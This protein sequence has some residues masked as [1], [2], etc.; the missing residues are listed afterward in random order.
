[1]WTKFNGVDGQIFPPKM[2]SYVAVKLYGPGHVVAYNYIADFHDGINIETYGNPDGS[3]ASGPGI[4][5]GPHYPP[6]EYW[7]RRPG[8]DRLLQQ[9]HHQ[10]ARQPDRDRR[11]H[12]QHPRAAEH[13]HQ[14]RV[15]R[16]LQPAVARRAGL[17]DPQHRLPPAGRLDAA[18]ERIGGRAVLQQHHPV[19]DAGGRRVERALAQQPDARRERGAGDPQRDHDDQLHVVG[20][21]RVPPE[22]RR[23]GVVPVERAAGR[24]AGRLHR[25]RPHRGAAERAASRRWPSTAR[26][27][28]RTRTA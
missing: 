7:D 16:V 2:A 27:P 13:V 24:R 5:E 1:M 14:P 25:P 9:L 19:G 28:A 10:L 8:G 12:A 22:P 15:A 26:R 4:I 20:L 18:D 21:Q 6:R 17:L 11:R 3:V 23:E